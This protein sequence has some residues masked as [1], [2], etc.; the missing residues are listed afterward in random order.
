MRP[1]SFTA[2]LPLLPGIL[3]AAGLCGV[4]APSITAQEPANEDEWYDPTD[5]FDGNN[6]EWDD[7]YEPW[8]EGVANG[9]DYFDYGYDYDSTRYG[10]HFQWD[11]IDNQW[12]RAYGWF[13]DYY[14]YDGNNQYGWH[15][16]WDPNDKQWDRTYGWFD[17]YYDYDSPSRSSQG[18][19]VLTGTV[20]SFRRVR[21][22]DGSHTLVRLR[23]EDGRTRV[24]DL[25]QNADLAKLSL[26][27]GDRVRIRGQHES[28]SGRD[29]FKADALFVDGERRSI[30][31]GQS[32]QRNDGSGRNQQGQRQDSARQPRGNV[33]FQGQVA[34]FSVVTPRGA[35]AD[36]LLVRMRLRDGSWRVVDFGP[37][38]KLGDIGLKKGERV[39]V[40]GRSKEMDGQMVLIAQQLHAGGERVDLDRQGGR[41]QQS[42][43]EQ[44][45]P[46]QSR[47]NRQG[48]QAQTVSGEVSRLERTRPEGL[49]D[50]MSDH[51]IVRLGM[52]DG[53]TCLVDFGPSVTLSEIGLETGDEIWMQG[54]N[55]EKG[56]K[57]VFTAQQVRVNGRS[58]D[59]EAMR[60]TGGEGV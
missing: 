5:W 53:R 11:P 57:S 36:H 17:E 29:V 9:Y 32:T 20:D 40:R 18:Q 22:V 46:R 28:Y 15:Y 45:R 7:T 48:N 50:A 27:Q 54:R 60:K 49:P 4:L 13:D 1:S 42:Q 55:Q 19:N 10:W 33:T 43:P 51:L 14:D 8:D 44:G 52:E 26:H 30:P 2:T 47:Q 59:L 12:E 31:R 24:I 21:N 34:G 25:G 37:S 16:Q 6:I 23:L 39:T 41:N 3:L 58:F 35:P 56:G 38:A